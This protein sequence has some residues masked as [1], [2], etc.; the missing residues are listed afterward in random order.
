LCLSPPSPRRLRIEQAGQYDL[1]FPVETAAT[2][3]TCEIDPVSEPLPV[4]SAGEISALK[5]SRIQQRHAPRPQNRKQKPPA[6]ATTPDAK[7]LVSRGEAAA[8]LSISIR[9]VDYM[10]ADG[11][12][13]TRRIA[14]RVLIPT[15]EIRKFAQSDHPRRLAG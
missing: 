2:V 7:L 13:S 4:C 9:G 8:I 14:N 10:I 11:R 1:P 15:E 6:K 5:D 3:N 12:L